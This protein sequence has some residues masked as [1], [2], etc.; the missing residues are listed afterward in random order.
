ME[1]NNLYKNGI[2]QFES[3]HLVVVAE[4]KHRPKWAHTTLQDAGDLFGDPANTRRTQSNFKEPLVALT[5]TEPLPSR[6]LFLVH[7]SDP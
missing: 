1:S 7:Y 2:P 6:H 3:E 4:P 5:A